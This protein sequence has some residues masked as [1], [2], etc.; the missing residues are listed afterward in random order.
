MVWATHAFLESPADRHTHSM[1]VNMAVDLPPAVAPAASRPRPDALCAVGGGA[2]VGFLVRRG[3]TSDYLGVGLALVAAG[4]WASYILLN[5][6]VGAR[7]P[8]LQAPAVATSCS[9]L[10]Y[11]PVAAGA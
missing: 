6:L 11:L 7:L 10:I 3:P 1:S 5:R 8:G 9:A 4:C 2:G